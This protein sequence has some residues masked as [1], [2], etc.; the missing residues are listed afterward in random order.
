MWRI[1]NC[2]GMKQE[3]EQAA[4]NMVLYADNEAYQLG[5]EDGKEWQKKK[6]LSELEQQKNVVY[7]N[8]LEYGKRQ[9]YIEGFNDA[10][11][12]LNR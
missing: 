1:N 9:G 3:L 4:G 6:M 12:I 8:G 2:K 7:K 5:F 10:Y 11:D